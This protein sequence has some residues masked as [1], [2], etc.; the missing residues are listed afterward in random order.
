M[1]IICSTLYRKHIAKLNSGILI[2][3]VVVPLVH[4]TIALTAEIVSALTVSM[5][6]Y[7]KSKLLVDILPNKHYNVFRVRKFQRLGNAK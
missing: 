1:R 3:T 2:I 4:V 5:K 6:N 7:K